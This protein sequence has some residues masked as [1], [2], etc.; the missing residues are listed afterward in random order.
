MCATFQICFCI[1]QSHGVEVK[2]KTH[3]AARDI[4]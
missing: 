3:S 4:W 2:E 1:I